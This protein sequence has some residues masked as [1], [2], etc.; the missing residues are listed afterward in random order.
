MAR[1][2]DAKC[3]QCRREG[4]KLFLKGEKCFTDKCAVERRSYAP[5]QHGQR[6]IRM[7][8][9]GTQLREKQKVRR[10]YGL[11]ERQFR[12]SYAEADRRKGVTGENL[13]QLLESRL[14]TV[15]YR[16]GFGASRSEARQIVRHNSIL[17]NGK[18]VNIP[19][20]QLRQGDVVEVA[21]KARAQLR[22]KAALEAAEQRGLPE[23][24]E[25]D[26]KGMKGVFK[27]IP[28]RSDLPSNINE[29]LVVE[30]YSK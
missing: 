6:Q 10:I 12:K 18:R 19:S 5:G 26:A 30:L 20:F 27:S 8:N 9:Y 25:V 23:W 24:L 17:V 22:I 14:D 3:R 16:M 1:N 15:I 28:Q 7:S 13:L 4:E 11:L 21:E 2:L 29:S